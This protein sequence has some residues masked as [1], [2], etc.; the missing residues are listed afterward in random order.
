MNL[1]QSCH[2]GQLKWQFSF[3][4]A[5]ECSIPFNFAAA[6]AIAFTQLLLNKLLKIR[7]NAT[8]Q[9]QYIVVNNNSNHCRH[10]C[11]AS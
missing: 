8:F 7:E 6:T 10:M 5:Q 9:Q 4:Y 3:Y 11:G 1:L 2:Y